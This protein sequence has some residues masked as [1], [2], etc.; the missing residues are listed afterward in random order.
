MKKVLFSLLVLTSSLLAYIRTTDVERKYAIK[1]RSVAATDTSVQNINIGFAN[2]S[3]NTKTLNLN[4][5]YTLEHML[6]SDAYEPFK[7]NFQATGFLTK[8]DGDKTSEEYTALLNGEQE[9]IGEWLGYM[10]LD[11]LRNVFKNYNNKYTLATGIGKV[12]QNDG[13]YRLVIKIGPTYNIEQYSN[14]QEDERFGSLSEYIEY[15]NKLNKFSK[16]YFK[17]GAMENFDDMGKDYEATALLGLNF[18]L[19]ENVHI[20]IEEELA[21]DNLPPLGFDKTDTKSIVRVGYKF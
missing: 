3:G 9:L 18:I 14:N 17:L 21:Y 10:T 6:K 7:Y 4:I 19:N 5:K 2:T 16:L 20:T 11:W 15:S 1:C 12:L 13:K 8:D